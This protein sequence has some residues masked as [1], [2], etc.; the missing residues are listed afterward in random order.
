MTERRWELDVIR[1][2]ACFF[3]VVIHVFAY[4]VPLDDPKTLEW[5]ISNVTMSIVKSAVPLF[6]M[7]SGT[8]F[9][10]KQKIS[11]KELYTKNVCKIISVMIV[12]ELFMRFLTAWNI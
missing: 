7:I 11:L 4:S 3:V 1:I 9:L 5:C 10:E 8:L 6:F 2:I 12:W